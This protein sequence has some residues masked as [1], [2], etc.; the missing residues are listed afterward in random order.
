MTAALAVEEIFGLEL[1]NDNES[2]GRRRAVEPYYLGGKDPLH[3]H[4]YPSVARQQHLLSAR[5]NR[6]QW[7]RRLMQTPGPTNVV[8]PLPTS[9]EAD[10][11]DLKE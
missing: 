1:S 8:A 6:R 2:G 4:V 7:E 11:I 10:T 5:G 9:G 3:P